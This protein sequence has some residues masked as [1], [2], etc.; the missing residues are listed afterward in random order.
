MDVPH[1]VRI[2]DSGVFV[3]SASWSVQHQGVRNVSHGCV[4]ISPA[5]AEWF[6]S[7]FGPGD[8]VDIVNTGRELYDGNGT[9]DW[10]E[11]WDEWLAGSALHGASSAS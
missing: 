9:T 6:Y 11:S 3:H 7:E 10:N 8:V 5:N 4:N 2:T 1:A